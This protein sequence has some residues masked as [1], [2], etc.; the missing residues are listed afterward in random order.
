MPLLRCA[1]GEAKIC[2]NKQWNVSLAAVHSWMSTKFAFNKSD[3]VWFNQLSSVAS[4]L[5]GI[6][7]KEREGTR[8][9]T[10]EATREGTRE[11]E[12]GC[13]DMRRTLSC[14]C[15]VFTCGGCVCVCANMHIFINACVLC[16]ISICV[17]VCA[18]ACV[19]VIHTCISKFSASQQAWCQSSGLLIKSS[20]KK[21][22]GT[23]IVISLPFSYE[24]SFLIKL[25]S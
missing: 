5:S 3:F 1:F 25:S 17:C 8:E 4:W 16:C 18:R 9:G 21:L 11:G 14:V 19:C 2:Q 10:R 20:R 24:W 7:K 22:L 12:R 23:A 13:G 15:S 6:M